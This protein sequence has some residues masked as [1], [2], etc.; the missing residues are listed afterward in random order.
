MLEIMVDGWVGLIRSQIK[1]VRVVLDFVMY[2]CIIIVKLLGLLK[3]YSYLRILDVRRRNGDFDFVRK[4]YCSR[5]GIVYCCE[6]I[7][8]DRFVFGLLICCL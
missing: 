3:F 1:G 2:F 8:C 5:V 4:Y 6:E 7:V